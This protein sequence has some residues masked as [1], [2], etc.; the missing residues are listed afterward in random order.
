MAHHRANL[1]VTM[2]QTGPLPFLNRTGK[3]VIAD[4]PLLR[5]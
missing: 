5:L 2:T 1:E 4:D 3:C